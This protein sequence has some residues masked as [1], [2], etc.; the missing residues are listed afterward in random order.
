MSVN[1]LNLPKSSHTLQYLSPVLTVQVYIVQLNYCIVVCC[2]YV[3]KS[4]FIQ[5]FIVYMKCI[6]PCL[7]LIYFYM[8]IKYVFVFPLLWEIK[9]EDVSVAL[10]MPC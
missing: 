1:N 9:I 5:E 3:Y 4:Y 6:F 10:H 7:Q 2:G 8:G